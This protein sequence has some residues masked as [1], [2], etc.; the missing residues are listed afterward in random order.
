MWERPEPVARNER[1]RDEV[2]PKKKALREMIDERVPNGL[3]INF[4]WHKKGK[5][6]LNGNVNEGIGNNQK[7]T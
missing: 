7:K 5:G 3:E 1:I 6:K 4:G 2:K